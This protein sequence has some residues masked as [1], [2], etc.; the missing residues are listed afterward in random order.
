MTSYY[1]QEL[2]RL[3][4]TYELARVSNI[5]QLKVGIV[6]ASEASVIGVGSGGS[7]TVASLLCT[8][9]EAYTGRV[10]RPS[11]PLEIISNPTLASASPIFFVSA[12]GKNPDIVEALRRARRHSARDLHVLTNRGAS[13]LQDTLTELTDVNIHTFELEHKDGYLATNSLILDAVLIARA[14][15]ELDHHDDHIPPTI[16]DLKLNGQSIGAWLEGAAGFAQN[17]ASRDGVI[18]L[19]SPALKSVA[20][21]LESKL[22]E[23][24]LLHCQ[25]ADLRSF[26]HGRHSWLTERAGDNL[27]LA[28]VDP[29][30]ERLW[31][32]THALLP[33]EIETLTL[34]I[35]GSRPRDLLSGLIAELKLVS[36]FAQALGKD[37]AKPTVAQFGRELYYID[38]PKL[39][40]QPRPQTNSA[41]QSKFAV[42]GAHWPSITHEEPMQRMASSVRGSLS[43][44]AFRAVVF[45][46]D[47]TISS[48]N[49]RDIPPTTQVCEY[50]QKLAEHGVVVGI[51]SGR[52]DSIH[53]QLRLVL[54]DAC[55]PKI[56][57]G[58]FSGGWIGDL[59]S[60]ISQESQTSEFLNHAA[61]IVHNL[62]HA[63]V[64]IDMVRVY[65][66]HQVSVRFQPGI[67][68]QGMWFVIVDALRHAGVDFSNVVRS[69]HSVDILAP[70]VSKSRLVTHLIKSCKLDP[71]EV[72]T[73]G[74]QGAWP[75]NDSSLLDHKFSLSVA[76]PSR[77]LDR[78]WKIAPAHKRDVDATLW[79][80]DAIVFLNAGN[81]TFDAARLHEASAR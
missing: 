30:S 55:W 10:S 76:T 25:V 23:A 58:L 32:A 46:Y 57:L 16:D 7:Y 80:L 29:L 61:R 52:G 67:E 62:K 28:L 33:R 36:L 15:E 51:A 17:V 65:H 19:H 53:A 3:G 60:E 50:L 74:D 14:Y 73:M 38:L 54:P 1:D 72:L 66:P 35:A 9:H 47:G 59:S 37:P 18:V 4:E 31:Q 8:L 22:S 71:Y 56:K 77:K 75:G 27:V 45:D 41:E 2:S 24:A 39:V 34:N 12:E 63:G 20:A 48:S 44:K 70:G 69:R 21:D 6:N 42:L 13:P 68:A 79:Y 81:F 64:P 11:T 5:Q 78:G 49:R 26:A 43:D 40:E